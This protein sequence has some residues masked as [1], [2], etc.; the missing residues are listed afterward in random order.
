MT[1]RTIKEVTRPLVD[2]VVDQFYV[3]F[4]Q[5]PEN[6][7]N[8]LG[9]QV[10][11]VERPS[12]NF[13][14]SENFNKNVKQNLPG[15]IDFQPITIIFKDDDASLVA[16]ALYKQIERQNGVYAPSFERSKFEIQVE[17]F[18]SDDKKVEEIL[19][20]KCFIS[21]IS[22]SEHIYSGSE[23]NRITVTLAFDTA[24]YT[25]PVLDL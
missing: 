21:G 17:V 14:M 15:K 12:L 9:R 16:A 2:K 10:E 6:I 22:H 3:K 1:D 11:S 19:I 7:S 20:K 24:C 13:N 25:Y 4:F 18:S 8:I 23:K 5:L